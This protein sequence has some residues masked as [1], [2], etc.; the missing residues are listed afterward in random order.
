MIYDTHQ[1]N[2]QQLNELKQLIQ[3]CKKK[4]ESTPCLYPYILI[5]QRAFPASLLYYQQEQLVA[6]LSVYFFYDDA[7]EIG[8]LVDPAYRQKGFAKGLLSTII[9][10][11]EFQN[12]SKLIFSVPSKANNQHFLQKGY[13]YSHSEYRMQRSELQPILE[14]KQHL[15]FRLAIVDDISALCT[16]DE[17]CFPKQQGDLI[18]RFMY[19]LNYREYKIILAFHEN[20]LI[21]KAHIRWEENGATFSDIA[22][23]PEYQGKGYGSSLISYCINHALEEGKPLLHLD[24]ETHNNR[25]LNLY[26]RL[27][28]SVENAC[29]FWTI[30][31]SQLKQLIG[32]SAA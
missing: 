31:L 30:E 14:Y 17:L 28:F 9:P 11:I 4:D 21:G 13:L 27:G 3:N 23:A 24:V 5:Q 6:F 7:V 18:D 2:E 20:T 10:L 29:D 26:T 22:V 19:L 8:L 15:N 1:L 12:Y 16:L 32:I 25:A